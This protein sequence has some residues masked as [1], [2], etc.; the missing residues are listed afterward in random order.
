MKNFL[1]TAFAFLTINGL[2][3]LCLATAANS[4][5]RGEYA[6]VVV[7]LGIALAFAG[8]EAA[9]ILVLRGRVEPR[10]KVG[11]RETTIRPDLMFDR[12]TLWATVI[13][14]IAV[15]VYA[16]CAP[17]GKI[18]LPLPYGS[19]R[20]WSI[21]ASVLTVVGLANIWSLFK[22]GGNSFQRLN[23]RG[24]ELGQGV[25]SVRGEWDDVIEIT[26]RRPGK[27][28]PLRSTLF[29]EFRD[30][31]IWAQAVDSYTPGGEALRRLVR[32]YWINTDKREELANGS[33]C[34]RLREFE[35]KP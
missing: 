7:V 11:N 6:T 25:S 19:Q 15:A 20:M 3:I 31:K 4:I 16:I 22:R 17:Q 10:M 26:D 18:D 34:E 12:L 33:A 28:P 35:D 27:S 13:V 14:V 9:V 5:G 2:V 23:P 1:V 32:Y 24:F 21:A 29:V 8:V 30:G